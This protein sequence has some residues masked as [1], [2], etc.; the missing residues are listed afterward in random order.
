MPLK[1]RVTN[2]SASAAS[3]HVPGRRL[4]Q[5]GAL[6]AAVGQ[7]AIEQLVF[8]LGREGEGLPDQLSQLDNLGAFGAKDR[9]EGIVLVLG[10]A[11]SKSLLVGRKGKARANSP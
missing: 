7:E 6:D 2:C 8:G 4:G 3:G 9:R 1:R 5:L 10:R 11:R